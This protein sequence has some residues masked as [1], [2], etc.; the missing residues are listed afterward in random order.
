ME[1]SLF[2]AK[3]MGCY[4]LIAGLA[5]LTQRRVFAQMTKEMSEH[6]YLN[7][8]LSFL[9]TILGLIIVFSHN[10]WVADWRVLVTIIGWITLL[11]GIYWI[12]FS[13]HAKKSL[14]WWQNHKAF[15]N[16][17]GVFI[18]LMGAFLVYHGF[19]SHL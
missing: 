13:G 9:I 8:I 2:L 11:K 5:Y 12:F 4:F 7:Y 14:I 19:L 10:L 17:T 16:L 3:V 15:Y 1:L 18:L 6:F